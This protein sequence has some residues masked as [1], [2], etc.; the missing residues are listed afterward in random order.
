MSDAPTNVGS[1]LRQTLHVLVASKTQNRSK[2]CCVLWCYVNSGLL[3]EHQTSFQVPI[4]VN[5][6]ST[7][8]MFD[9]TTTS[10]PTQTQ[11]VWGCRQTAPRPSRDCQCWRHTAVPGWC[12]RGCGWRGRCGSPG[13]PAS[14]GR[15]SPQSAPR[16]TGSPGQ[17]EITI[18]QKWS[19][20]YC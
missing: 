17:G 9:F 11:G 14:S 2:W 6:L 18:I 13:W 19:M 15:C 5:C 16:W 20:Y 8:I 10:P 4:Y 12:A 3:S 7:M 1:M